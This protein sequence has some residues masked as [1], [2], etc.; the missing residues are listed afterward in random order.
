MD[1]G[2]MLRKLDRG[3]YQN[4]GGVAKDLEQIVWK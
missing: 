3:L 1:V 2:K 4:L